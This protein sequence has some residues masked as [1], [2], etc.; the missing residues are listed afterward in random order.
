MK[1]SLFQDIPQNQTLRHAHSAKLQQSRIWD[2]VTLIIE[3]RKGWP[4]AYQRQ[5]AITDSTE[6]SMENYLC[7]LT[8]TA[9]L[10]N[11][12]TRRESAAMALTS[13]SG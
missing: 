13:L 4:F 11:W 10:P 1:M 2:F 7:R 8:T 5:L 9:L 3:A 6:N 12:A